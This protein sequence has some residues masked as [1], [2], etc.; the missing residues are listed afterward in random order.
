MK[1]FREIL[2][3][4]EIYVEVSDGPQKISLNRY[5]GLSTKC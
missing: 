3:G 1:Y 4:H 5:G 2:M